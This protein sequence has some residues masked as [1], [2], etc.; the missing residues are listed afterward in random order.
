MTLDELGVKHRT[1]KS[2][3][4]HHYLGLY[5][6]LFCEIASSYVDQRIL[7]IG[8]QFGNSLKTWQEYFRFPVITGI[9]SVNNNVHIDRVTILIADAY[10]EQT[11]GLLEDR[12]FD[13]IIDDGSHAMDDQIFVVK[14]YSKLLSRVGLL[15]VEDV[16]HT[17]AIQVLK[18]SLPEGFNYSA[19]DMTEGNSTVDSRLFIAY[20]K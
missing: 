14:H 6:L 18:Q 5:E 11:V 1:D 12:E 13:I 19:V 2:S 8:V 4:N 16:L 3:L 15:I 9:D 7:E 17:A 10:S 20:R